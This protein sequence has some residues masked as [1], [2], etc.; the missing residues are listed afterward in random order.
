ML[1][2][3][4][5]QLRHEHIRSLLGKNGNVRVT[6]LAEDLDVSVVTIR[7]D[8]GYLEERS[9]LR[10]N[11]GGAVQMPPHRNEQALEVTSLACQDEKERI[12]KRA[13]RLIE[14][15]DTIIIDVGSTLTA[16]AQAFPPDLRNVVVI[17]NALNI[18][19]ILESH[20]G[21][22][23]IV[24]GGT[25]RP[26]QH[27]LVNPLGGGLLAQVNAD[28]AFIGCNGV[29]PEKGFTNSNLQEAEIKQAMLAASARVYFLADHTKLNAV[30]T[31][32]IAPL[33][34]AEMLI[35]DNAAAR[36]HLKL[37]KASGL[38]VDVA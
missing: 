16:L 1:P 14:D 33:S 24:T 5:A 30:S 31:A 35:T 23:L 15:N 8:L 38:A 6:E 3:L 25:L 18:A 27:S 26:L 12:A 13:A 11:R 17:T 4:D 37:L 19:M 7:A 9:E 22:T 28:K 10:R 2:S 36:E 32:A 21:V 29:H 34:C 20:P